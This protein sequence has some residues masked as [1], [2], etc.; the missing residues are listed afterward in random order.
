MAR[1][2]PFCAG[3]NYYCR[4]LRTATTADERDIMAFEPAHPEGVG[5]VDYLQRLAFPDEDAGFMRTYLVRDNDSD[6]LAAYFSLKAG[7]ASQGETSEG[8][9]TKFDTVPGIE[10]ANFA[11][12]GAFLR[13]HPKAKGL[14]EAVFQELVR[15]AVRRAGE[16]VGVALIYL[17][18]LPDER[19]IANY[20]RYGFSRLPAGDEER[21]HARLKPRYDDS[22]VFM[23]LVV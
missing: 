23:Y 9:R 1:S 4:S 22:C 19:V 21:L 12:N 18:S 13:A 8:G 14:G 6:E 17:F 11:V 2:E 10:L 7:L 20:G 3:R 5:L 16:I 15:E